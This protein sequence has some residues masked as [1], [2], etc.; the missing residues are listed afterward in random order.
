[1]LVSLSVAGSEV[2][3][4]G[5]WH[6]KYDRLS[7]TCCHLVTG[8]WQ[9]WMIRWALNRQETPWSNVL[10]QV[11]YFL[12]LYL[13]VTEAL[14]V[15]VTAESTRCWVTCAYLQVTEALRVCVCDS[16]IDKILSDLCIPQKCCIP[17]NVSRQPKCHQFCQKWRAIQ[18]KQFH[19]IS[20]DEEARHESIDSV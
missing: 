17:Q 10:L 6:N 11:A 20:N 13:Q 1:M 12:N 16:R 18:Y 14:R 8:E 5:V 4:S 3:S 7:V 9:V 15:C 2:E 19:N